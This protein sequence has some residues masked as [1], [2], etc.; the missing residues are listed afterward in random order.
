MLQWR[1]A[2][3]RELDLTGPGSDARVTR[4]RR[5]SDHFEAKFYEIL[6]RRRQERCAACPAE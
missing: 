3:L 2:P 4:L 1:G 6:R 5:F